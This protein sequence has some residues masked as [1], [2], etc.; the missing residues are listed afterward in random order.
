MSCSLLRSR[1]NGTQWCHKGSRLEE[2]MQ[3]N[4]RLRAQWN[5]ARWSA[6]R[7]NAPVPSDCLSYYR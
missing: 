6:M 2:G 5:V 3:W 4:R 1:I 7:V